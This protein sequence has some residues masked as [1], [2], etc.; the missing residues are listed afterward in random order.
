MKLADSESRKVNHH[1]AVE[2]VVR[3]GDFNVFN[4]WFIFILSNVKAAIQYTIWTWIG[5]GIE[6]IAVRE[7]GSDVSN[8]KMTGSLSENELK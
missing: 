4:D 8:A 1:F 3:L 2:V 5:G 6:S 7:H